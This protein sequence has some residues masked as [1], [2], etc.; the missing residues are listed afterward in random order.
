MVPHIPF[1]ALLGVL[2]GVQP[3][4]D[5]HSADADQPAS[6]SVA[7]WSA[8]DRPAADELASILAASNECGH[9][10][11][12]E[13]DDIA[14]SD[15]HQMV[16]VDPKWAVCSGGPGHLVQNCASGDGSMWAPGFC[17]PPC[18]D[19]EL[20]QQFSQ[21]KSI[22]DEAGRELQT[23]YPELVSYL[24]DRGKLVVRT[25]AGRDVEIRVTD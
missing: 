8:P 25:C 1:A 12:V 7:S 14:G 10:E 4:G 16:P 11:S 21:T 17:E 20:L 3:V 18:P 5:P 9:C 24:P 19:G 2:V 6:E 15:R 13:D 22:S 23:M